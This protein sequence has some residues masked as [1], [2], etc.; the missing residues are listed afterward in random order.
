M[1][2]GAS[3]GDGRKRKLSDID[4]L[5]ESSSVVASFS[6]TSNSSRMKQISSMEMIANQDDD[7]ED[8]DDEILLVVELLD[9]KNHPIFDKVQKCTIEV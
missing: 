1:T 5:K 3:K 6:S 8:E 2:K 4:K 7:S 9:F